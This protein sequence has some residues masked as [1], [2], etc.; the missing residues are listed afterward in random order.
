M[1]EARED[2][3]TETMKAWNL[4]PQK[5]EK[6]EPGTVG[7]EFADIPGFHVN[8]D[9]KPV[10]KFIKVETMEEAIARMTRPFPGKDFARADIVKRNA[11][12]T[13][14][15]GRKKNAL[16]DFK[17]KVRALNQEQSM[18][19]ETQQTDDNVLALIDEKK[20]TRKLVDPKGVTADISAKREANR[21][22]RDEA[23]AQ[24]LL[25]QQ[26]DNRWTAPRSNKRL[27][28]NRMV[29]DEAEEVDPEEA[30]RE[31]REAY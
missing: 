8:M 1:M 18:L 3:L 27:K 4:E 19:D 24:L 23:Q 7:A 9:E 10:T 26:Q 6:V 29:D 17:T 11:E 28:R 12:R 2:V 13:S 21:R 14:L 30:E 16:R 20:T 15:V 31:D 25:E 5:E 22:A